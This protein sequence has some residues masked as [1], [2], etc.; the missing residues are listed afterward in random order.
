V[1]FLSFAAPS[2]SQVMHRTEDAAAIS[3]H[4]ETLM[5]L[6]YDTAIL[7]SASRSGHTLAIGALQVSDYFPWRLPMAPCG[8]TQWP[9]VA[10]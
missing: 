2:L 7:L 6:Q 10:L 8:H 4:D 3:M 5:Q 1:Q 9:F